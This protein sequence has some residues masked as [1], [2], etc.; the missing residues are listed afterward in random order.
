VRLHNLKGNKSTSKF[1]KRNPHTIYNIRNWLVLN[2]KDFVLLSEEYTLATDNNLLWECSLCGHKWNQR[3]SYIYSSCGRCPECTKKETF[4]NQ[5]F[6]QEHFEEVVKSK[7]PNI[8][9]IGEYRGFTHRVECECIIHN[10]TWKPLAQQLYNGRGCP[11]CIGRYK[12]HFEFL[13]ELD[14]EFLDLEVLGE[15]IGCRDKILCRC[16]KMGHEWMASPDSLRRGVSCPKCKSSK[17]E[18]VIDMFLNTNNIKFK[19]QYIFEDC[20][21]KKPLEFDFYLFDYNTAIEYQGEQH[22]FPV[23]FAGMS[24]EKAEKQFDKQALRDQIKNEYCKQNNI[25]L[26]RIPYWEFKNIESI[27]TKELNL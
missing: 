2:N 27:L 21:N 23:K 9:I 22:Y 17:G 14:L 12:T 13:K 16:N 25:H 6:S 8:N 4:D 18:K 10:F 3:W 7:N 11:K 24:Q 26:L 15:Y 20:K 19:D 1:E 5:R